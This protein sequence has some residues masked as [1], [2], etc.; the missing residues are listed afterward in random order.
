MATEATTTQAPRTPNA[1][2][3]QQLAGWLAGQGYDLDDATGIASAA[4]V[5]VYDYYMTGGPGY[6]GKLMSVVWDGSP[7]TFDVFTW[8]GGEMI[9]EVRE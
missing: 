8:Q 5:A 2:E 4:Y 9:C 7:S 3:L 6:V 1:E